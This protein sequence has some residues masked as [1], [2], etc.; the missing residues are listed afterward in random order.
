MKAPSIT[1]K[2]G[3]VLKSIRI[4]HGLTQEQLATE[5]NITESYL[6][7]L[8]IG[9]KPI[10]YIFLEDFAKYFDMPVS[11]LVYLSENIEN[12]KKLSNKFKL[13]ARSKLLSILEWIGKRG[14]SYERV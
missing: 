5:L 6:A 8:E 2:D 7:G 10:S 13:L 12:P 14:K 3:R 11:T 4:F 1:K 9:E